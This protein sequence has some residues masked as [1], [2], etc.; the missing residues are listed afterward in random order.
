MLYVL[1]R[2]LGFLA[3]WEI[4]RILCPKFWC[5]HFI[6]LETSEPCCGSAGVWL[7]I[8]NFP[9]CSHCCWMF[10]LLRVCLC[11]V[12]GCVCGTWQLAVGRQLP[13]AVAWLQWALS[14][15]W[16][17]FFMT[18]RSD[19][20]SCYAG[21]SGLVVQQESTSA[22]GLNT[23]DTV[24]VWAAGFFALVRSLFVRGVSE[25]VWVWGPPESVWVWEALWYY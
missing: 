7:Y 9:T 6:S 1:L 24:W 4:F 8:H 17:F 5:T 2:L 20:T 14:I 19:W 15:N 21:R 16:L 3:V 25:C 22:I 10:I 11:L 13:L 23:S 12:C 18:L